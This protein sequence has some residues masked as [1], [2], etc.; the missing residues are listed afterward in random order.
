MARRVF[1]SFHY[2]RDISRVNVVRNHDVAKKDIE[3]SGYW[4][5]SLWEEKKKSGDAALVTLVLEGLKNTSVT[6]VLAGAETATRRWVRYEIAKSFERGNG[7]ILVWV[8]QIKNLNGAVDSRGPDPFSQFAFK[9]SASGATADLTIGGKPFL[10]ISTANMPKA[11]VAKKTGFI[12]EYAVAYDW[13]GD[14]GFQNF[15]SWVERSA[16][17]SGH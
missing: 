17:R 13:T 1:F 8:N 4:D 11:A 2:A 12:A 14:N 15:K 7:L 5:H 9:V 10:T 3:Q 6:V 16:T